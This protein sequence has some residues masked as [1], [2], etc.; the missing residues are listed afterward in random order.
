MILDCSASHPE[1]WMQNLANQINQPIEDGVIQVPSNMGSGYIKQ[2]QFLPDFYVTL[3]DFTLNFPITVNKNGVQD[4]LDYETIPIT[5]FFSDFGVTQHIGQETVEMGLSSKNGIFMASSEISNQMIIS[6]GK[7]GLIIT[8][9][10]NRN[11]LLRQI[12]G[13]GGF[14][15]E[16]LSKPKPFFL[17]EEI[18][19]PM[20]QIISQLLVLD[21]NNNSSS[22]FLFSFA[23]SLELLTL[24]VQKAD[25][26]AALPY[27]GMSDFEV[28]ALFKVKSTLTDCLK[29]PPTIE[30]LA[31]LAAMSEA[32]LQRSFKQVF[33]KSVYQYS[34]TLRMQEAKRLLD[35]LKYS[36]SEVGYKIGYSNLSH[37]TE[38][39][40]KEFEV[41]PKTYLKSKL[42]FA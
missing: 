7:R 37:F 3:M 39:F 30:E 40:R 16:L 28:E 9:C 2:I 15:L 10:A 34:L 32:K 1:E 11:W 18:T 42:V 35:T 41:N 17:F 14:F 5:F 6:E 29:E 25:R 38:V 31:R 8:I 22:S 4:T 19:Q 23:K 26:R 12:K 36:V 20:Q 24:F 27:Q 13:S 21:S 33:G